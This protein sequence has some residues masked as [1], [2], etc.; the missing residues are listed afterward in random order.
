MV[1]IVFS[2]HPQKKSQKR[3]L[4]D[5]NFDD[6]MEIEPL[7]KYKGNCIKTNGYK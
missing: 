6:D 2:Q 3:K 7:L 5:D 4:Q 1:F